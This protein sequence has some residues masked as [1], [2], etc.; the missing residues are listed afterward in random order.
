MKVLSKWAIS[1]SHTHMY[2]LTNIHALG[3]AIITAKGIGFFCF[4]P[5]DRTITCLITS[6]V[7]SGTVNVLMPCKIKFY[8]GIAKLIQSIS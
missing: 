8:D 1:L 4:E 5:A 2:I 6:S 7:Q 3:S